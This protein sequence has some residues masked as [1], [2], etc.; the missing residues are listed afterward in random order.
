[1]GMGKRLGF[2]LHPSPYLSFR[3]YSRINFINE[4]PGRTNSLWV[5]LLKIWR[6]I[7]H[8]VHKNCASLGPPRV[9][10]YF[11]VT[12]YEAKEKGNLSWSKARLSLGENHGD[13][14]PLLHFKG[15][16]ELAELTATAV[17]R[18]DIPRAMHLRSDYTKH[19]CLYLPPRQQRGVGQE[20]VRYTSTRVKAGIQNNWKFKAC[21][22]INPSETAQ[23]D[24]S[25]DFSLMPWGVSCH[26]SDLSD[27]GSSNKPGFPQ[28]PPPGA[29]VTGR[30]HTAFSLFHHQEFPTP[31]WASAPQSNTALVL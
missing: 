29:G 30:N 26:Q 19:K 13:Q 1:M 10:P 22:G 16:A 3:V 17:I 8:C 18:G 2:L 28:V 24:T 20:A 5:Y 31:P 12:Y 4:R 6:S 21:W 9:S 25:T 11:Q 14:R 23:S 7:S 15:T 27:P